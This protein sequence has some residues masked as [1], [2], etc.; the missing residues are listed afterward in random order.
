LEKESERC[1]NAKIITELYDIDD[2]FDT[3]E[4]ETMKALQKEE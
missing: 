4:Y 3:F 1:R 2:E